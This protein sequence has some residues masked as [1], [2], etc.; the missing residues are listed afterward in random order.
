MLGNTICIFLKLRIFFFK[1]S[2]KKLLKHYN[3]YHFINR[4]KCTYNIVTKS[5]KN[6]F[7]STRE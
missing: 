1:Y 4:S 7:Y 6:Q 5:T 3:I 2:D